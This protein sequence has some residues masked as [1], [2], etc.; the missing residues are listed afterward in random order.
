MKIQTQQ[1][2]TYMSSLINMNGDVVA[3][4]FYNYELNEDDE[5]D[6]PTEHDESKDFL[7]LYDFMGHTM[8]LTFVRTYRRAVGIEY[9]L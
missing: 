6:F 4:E 9:D 5:Y 7:R 3:L 2:A 1:V 8:K